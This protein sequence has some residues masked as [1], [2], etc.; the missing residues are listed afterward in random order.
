MLGIVIPLMYMYMYVCQL[1]FFN[2]YY[3]YIVF[4]QNHFSYFLIIVP[5]RGPMEPYVYSV[6]NVL[7]FLISC[8]LVLPPL[9]QIL[10]Y[11]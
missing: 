10:L 5:D 7:S 8:K 9:C 1:T 11:I 4:I 6:I 3:V 2:I